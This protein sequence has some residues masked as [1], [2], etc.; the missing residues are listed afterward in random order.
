MEIDR[1]KDC[2]WWGKKPDF[3]E[4]DEKYSLSFLPPGDQHRN[5]EHPK[6]GGGTYNDRGHIDGLNSYESIGVGPEFGCIQFEE[7]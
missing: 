6:V 2:K 1:C 3:M 7:R 4:K 5:C